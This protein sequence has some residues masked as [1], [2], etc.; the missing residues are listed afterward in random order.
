LEELVEQTFRKS[1]VDA[2]G[3]RGGNGARGQ[4]PYSEGLANFSGEGGVGRERLEAGANTFQTSEWHPINRFGAAREMWNGGYHEVE[5][6]SEGPVYC[7]FN[8]S[9]NG[10]CLLVIAQ[11][12]LLPSTS[13]REP[14]IVYW[15]PV[16]SRR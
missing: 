9:R 8:Y 14:K 1:R 7:R 4:R 12:E 2:L 13:K 15:S 16:C 5:D 11:G 6:C 10:Q 3:L